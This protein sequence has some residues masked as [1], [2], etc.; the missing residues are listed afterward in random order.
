ME[1]LYTAASQTD[2][3][4]F[5]PP[6]LYLF[7]ILTSIPAMLWRSTFVLLLA[8]LVTATPLSRRWNDFAEKHSWVEVPKGWEL[9]SEAPSSYTFDLRIGLKQSRIDELIEN[10]MEISD[11]NHAQYVDFVFEE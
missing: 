5:L 11:P 6:H 9:Y 7:P 1:T 8:H 3:Q 2:T 4:R 10:L